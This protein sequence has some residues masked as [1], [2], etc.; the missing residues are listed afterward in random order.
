MA[1]SEYVDKHVV[2]SVPKPVRNPSE[3]SDFGVVQKGVSNI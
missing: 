1:D 3:L 2:L